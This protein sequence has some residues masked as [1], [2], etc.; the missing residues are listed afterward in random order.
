MKQN[1]NINIIVALSIGLLFSFFDNY[2]EEKEIEKLKIE[3][4]KLDIEL[5]KLDTEIKLIEN[6]IKENRHK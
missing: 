3:R 6:E 5:L 2:K 4:L 1:W